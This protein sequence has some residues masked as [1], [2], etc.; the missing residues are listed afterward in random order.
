MLEGNGRWLEWP[1]RLWHGKLG[2]GS[3]ENTFTLTIK[4]IHFEVNYNSFCSCN[5]FY[6]GRENKD[7]KE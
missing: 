7:Y 3:V 2:K 1:S 5:H 6:V 4:V